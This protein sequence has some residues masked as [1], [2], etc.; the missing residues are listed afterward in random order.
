MPEVCDVKHEPELLGMETMILV[1]GPQGSRLTLNGEEIWPPTVPEMI[2]GYHRMKK[3]LAPKNVLVS[4]IV[5]K[6]ECFGAYQQLQDD[7]QTIADKSKGT[8]SRLDFPYDW[9]TNILD[10]AKTLASVIE[11][12]VKKPS[13]SITLVCHSGGNLVARALLE[14]PHFRKKSWFD[15][16]TKYVG[17]CG[18]HFGVPRILTYALGLKGSMGISPSDMRVGAANPKFPSCYQ[19]LPFDGYRVLWDFKQTPPAAVN[20]Y[21]QATNPK[22]SPANLGAAKKLQKTIGFEKKPPNVQ[23]NLIAGSEHTTDERIDYLNPKYYV[24][25]DFDGDGMIPIQSST[26]SPFPVFVTPGDHIGIFKSYLFRSK[27][28]KILTGGKLKPKLSLADGKGASLSL[29]DVVFSPGEKI[30]LLIIPDSATEAISGV[31]LEIFQGD[32]KLK[33]FHPYDSTSL[34]YQGPSIRF[35][36][37]QITAPKDPGA[38]LITLKG[39]TH[40]TTAKTRAGFVVRKRT[41]KAKKKMID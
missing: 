39:K 5:D 31:S 26:H 23:Y 29:N 33:Q 7:L 15:N 2:S 25:N 20:F 24:E 9:R 10:S 38:Y 1:P 17:I 22:L 16:I 11:D 40:R 34:A 8:K 14:G 35:I 41:T 6:I 28:Y 3:L 30:Q 21:T 36:R 27:L 32:K 13:D 18:P 12:C 19:F 4:T 37:A